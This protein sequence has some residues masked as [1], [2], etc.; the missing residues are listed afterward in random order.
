MKKG[1]LTILKNNVLGFWCK[2]C[3]RYHLVNI[4]KNN[5]GPYWEFN[6]NYDRPTFNPSILV[7][8]P[9]ERCHSFVR[10]GQIQYLNDCDHKLAGQTVKLEYV[11]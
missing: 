6:G 7:T 10:D 8:T 4:D 1:V 9:K 5:D 11:D 2:G 3:N